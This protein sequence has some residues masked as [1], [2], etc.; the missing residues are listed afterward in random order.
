[1]NANFPNIAASGC[2]KVSARK[3]IL[4]IASEAKVTRF[5]A[6]FTFNFVLFKIKAVDDCS[7][8][9]RACVYVRHLIET[10]EDAGGEVG[11]Q[12]LIVLHGYAM[13]FP[14]QRVVMRTTETKMAARR[15]VPPKRESA[16]V[17]IAQVNMYVERQAVR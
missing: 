17:I 12:P 9:Y 8:L 15:R 4:M 2:I 10:I 14:D 16:C 7:V 1:M 6:H 11:L 13:C 5:K 3:S